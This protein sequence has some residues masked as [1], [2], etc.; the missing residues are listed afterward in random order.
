[1]VSVTDFCEL[2]GFSKDAIHMA[3]FNKANGK[4]NHLNNYIDGNMVDYEGYMYDVESVKNLKNKC[5]ILFYPAVHLAGNENRLGKI[6]GLITGR[7]QTTWT[8]WMNGKLFL[9]STDKQN[10]TTHSEMMVEFFW[11]SACLTV[12]GFK[13]GFIKKEDWIY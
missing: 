1:M 3:N 4:P 10:P 11:I 7:A 13:N 8:S 2:T 6:L 12:I 9:L 5:H